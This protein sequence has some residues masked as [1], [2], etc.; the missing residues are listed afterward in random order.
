ML[1]E[2]HLFSLLEQGLELLWR[3]FPVL[4]ISST[5]VL[6]LVKPSV[7]SRLTITAF[8]CVLYYSNPWVLSITAFNRVLYYSNS[9]VYAG[10]G[11]R[12]WHDLCAW[13]WWKGW[14]HSFSISRNF[15]FYTSTSRYNTFH[16][17]FQ[18]PTVKI[19]S[20]LI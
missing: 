17:S 15:N 5:K 8:N 12:C 1:Q 20:A 9:W 19:L 7:I 11:P 6:I 2:E 4:Y 16:L 10:L 13:S 14:H 18:V 3:Y